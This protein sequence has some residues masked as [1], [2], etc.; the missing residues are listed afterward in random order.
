MKQLV[1]W[2]LL[3]I[4]FILIIMSIL[5]NSDQANRLSSRINDTP[6]TDEAESQKPVNEF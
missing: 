2:V 5:I 4:I 6:I 3:V 1:L